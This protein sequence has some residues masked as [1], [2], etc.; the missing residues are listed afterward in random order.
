MKPQSLLRFALASILIPLGLYLAAVVVLGHL[1]ANA[2]W[3]APDANDPDVI[4]IFVQTNGVHTG[5]VMPVVA[6]GI[7]WRYRVRANDLPD[8]RG[9]GKWLAF[10]WGDRGFYLDTPTWRQARLSTIATAL[11]GGGST[12]MHVDHLD[13]FAA[14]ENWRPLRLRPAEYRRLA[15]FI[16]ASFA[17]RQLVTPG[18]TARDVFYT[19]RGH[20]SALRTCNVWTGDALRQAGVKM[21]RWTPFAGDVMR[22]V[23]APETPRR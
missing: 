5:I 7:D 16:E 12:V 19:A 15:A 9:A 17:D 3:R 10:G 14:D 22:W 18:Y 21:G 20:Y 11:T 4:T 8:P 13:D 6:Q 1:P 23:P 2:D